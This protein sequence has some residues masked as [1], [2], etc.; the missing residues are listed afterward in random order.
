MCRI[1]FLVLIVAAAVATWSNSQAAGSFQTKPVFRTTAA[2]AT[3][4]APIGVT[5][6]DGFGGELRCGRGRIRDSKTHASAVPQI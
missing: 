4:S 2:S 1:T 6:P 3:A 5:A